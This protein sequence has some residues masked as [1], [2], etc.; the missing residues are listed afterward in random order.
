MRRHR[1]EK[2]LWKK[3]IPPS[4]FLL[5]LNVLARTQIYDEYLELTN[6]IKNNS[7][8]FVDPVLGILSKNDKI[9]TNKIFA[10]NSKI[11]CNKEE[12]IF[13]EFIFSDILRS[14][15][16]DKSFHSMCQ[17]LKDEEI[18]YF[19]Q[20]LPSEDQEDKANKHE[21]TKSP[22]SPKKKNKK[23]PKEDDSDSQSLQKIKM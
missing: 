3:P 1:A 20:Y 10:Q 5:N 19:F 12:N 14:L 16:S 2:K 18:P 22:T 8:K 23:K 4:P 15:I 6:S 11:N 13:L 7:R 17:K 9:P 21:D